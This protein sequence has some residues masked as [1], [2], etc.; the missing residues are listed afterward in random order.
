MYRGG[1]DLDSMGLETSGKLWRVHRDL[2]GRKRFGLRGGDGREDGSGRERDEDGRDEEDEDEGSG[3][4][5]GDTALWDGYSEEQ[6][7]NDEHSGDDDEPEDLGDGDSGDENSDDEDSTFKDPD[8]D[9]STVMDSEVDYSVY[10]K[11]SGWLVIAVSED[12]DEDDWILLPHWT[13]LEESVDEP[14]TMGPFE[15]RDEEEEMWNRGP[16]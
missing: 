8:D 15:D 10:A 1:E 5:F 7:Y 4:A 13:L 12:E 14:G 6:S 16:V 11:D 9:D 2:F 3:E